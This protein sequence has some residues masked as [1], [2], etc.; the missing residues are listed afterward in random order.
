MTRACSEAA[1]RRRPAR[2]QKETRGARGRQ[3]RSTPSG[4]QSAGGNSPLHTNH[5]SRAGRR[6]AAVRSA[7][8]RSA[9]DASRPG[10]CR[11]TRA[12]RY[13]TAES[14][15]AAGEQRGEPVPAGY[16]IEGPVLRT[17]PAMPARVTAGRNGSAGGAFIQIERN[18]QF[19]FF[20]GSGGATGMRSA[21]RLGY[22]QARLRTT[23][24]RRAASCA[25]PDH[26]GCDQRQ[27]LGGHGTSR[28]GRKSREGRSPGI[29]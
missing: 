9:N 22:R 15:S 27:G 1:E 23:C 21:T 12:G 14:A 8:T 13:L 29:F 2:G 28:S 18:G 11:R 5:R 24:R 7:R 6:R 16:E 3:S 25:P 10:R 20:S 19:F 26:S 17:S 4:T